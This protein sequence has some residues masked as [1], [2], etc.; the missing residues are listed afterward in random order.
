[1]NEKLLTLYWNILVVLMFGDAVVGVIWLFRYNVLV[2]NLRSDLK[3]KLN[4]EYGFDASFQ[5]STSS[6]SISPLHTSLI[7]DLPN[8]KVIHFQTQEHLLNPFDSRIVQLKSV[9]Q[10]ES[11]F[12]LWEFFSYKDRTHRTSESSMRRCHDMLDSL[13]QKE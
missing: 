10:N 9:R 4:S 5:V 12:Q 6:S 3:M 2:T 8:K 13:F 11:W 7:T 1:M